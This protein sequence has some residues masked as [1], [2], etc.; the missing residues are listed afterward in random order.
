MTGSRYR[1]LGPPAFALALVGSLAG[2]LD[3]VEPE[4]APARLSAFLA[5]QDASPAE[6]DLSAVFLPGPTEVAVREPLRVWDRSFDPETEPNG[7]LLRYRATWVPNAG[8]LLRPDVEFEGPTL[9]GGSVR[10]LV[11]VPLIWRDGPDSLALEA[12][13]DLRLPLRG[14]PVQ[15]DGEDSGSWSVR[16]RA[17]DSDGD[18]TNTILTLSASGLPPGTVVVQGAALGGEEEVELLAT[19]RTSIH[20]NRSGPELPYPVAVTV[21]V[22]LNWHIT[23]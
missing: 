2:C 1:R 8:T 14:V 16:V 19:L 21:Q 3:L 5:L 18:P 4:P 15:L 7:D 20:V 17:L 10:P 12:D 13:S 22:Q 23:R 6:A 11:R 9:P